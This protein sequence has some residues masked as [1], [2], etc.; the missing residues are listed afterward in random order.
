MPSQQSAWSPGADKLYTQYTCSTSKYSNDCTN[1]NF[2]MRS[3]KQ[4]S[5]KKKSF[6]HITTAN[7]SVSVVPKPFPDK[8]IVPNAHTQSGEY[9]RG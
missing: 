7:C 6:L 5:E 9:F 1:M 2:S 4:C 8:L 3:I